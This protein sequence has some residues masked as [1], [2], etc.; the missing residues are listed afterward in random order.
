MIEVNG[1]YILPRH[2]S[3]L[4][5]AFAEGLMQ[6]I[7]LLWYSSKPRTHMAASAVFLLGYCISRFIIEFFRQPDADQ[8]F[9]L[10]RWMT[11][12]QILSAPMII[13]GL[14]MLIYAYKRGIYDWGK[15]SAY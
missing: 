4:Y 3:K 15:Q 9:I 13:A 7:F 10:L 5:K 14:I 1:Q 6:F 11:K 8:V 2:P 12:A